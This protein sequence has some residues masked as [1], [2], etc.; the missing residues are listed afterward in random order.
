MVIEMGDA[1]K[2]LT[3]GWWDG[4]RRR[5]R[6][7]A[8]LSLSGIAGRPCMPN[9]KCPITKRRLSKYDGAAGTKQ[10]LNSIGWTCCISRLKALKYLH[11]VTW[12]QGSKGWAGLLSLL[13]GHSQAGRGD[14]GWAQEAHKMR[15]LTVVSIMPQWIFCKSANMWKSVRKKPNK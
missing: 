12:L 13:H 6:N 15:A 11:Y 8:Y 10:K 4:S 7:S 5:T 1:C 9:P 3:D 14:R 2:Y